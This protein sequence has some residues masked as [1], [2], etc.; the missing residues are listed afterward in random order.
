MS[1]IEKN[2]AV[3]YYT[4]TPNPK[5]VW[6]AVSGIFRGIFMT[7]A[8]VKSAKYSPFH[9]GASVTFAHQAEKDAA[10]IAKP[11]IEKPAPAKP[12]P[13]KPVPAK[14]DTAWPVAIT[15]AM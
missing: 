11:A 12:A 1:Y 14:D 2:D 13:V 3:C 9:V 5:G 7:P 6:S 4:E 10:A 8:D 15:P